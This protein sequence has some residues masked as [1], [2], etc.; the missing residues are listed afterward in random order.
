M[1]ALEQR[2]GAIFQTGEAIRAQH[3]ASESHYPTVLPDAVVYA[4]STQDVVDCVNL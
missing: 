2:F 4:T 3:G 1:D